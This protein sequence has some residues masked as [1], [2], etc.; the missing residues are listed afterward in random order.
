MDEENLHKIAQKGEDSGT[1]F[2]LD[3][4]SPDAMA[5]EIVSFLNANG[6]TIYLGVS[7][8]GDIVGL[9]SESVRR[10]NQMI[11]NVATQHIR[12][13]VALFTENILLS[14]SKVVIAIKI[15]EGREKPYFDRNGIAWIKE[16]A[17]KRKIV[18]REEIRR[19]FESSG[20]LHA[21]EQWTKAGLDRLDKAAFKDF[22]R[23]TYNFQ[24]PTKVSEMSRIVRN[25]NLATDDGHLNLAGLLLFGNHPEFLFPQFCVKAVRLKGN[26]LATESFDD[27][28]DYVGTLPAIYAGVTFFV[29]RNLHKRQSAAGIN[30]PGQSEIHPAVVEEVLVNALLHRDYYVNAP[31]RVLIFDD[32][33]EVL[34]PGSLPNHLTVE[35]ILAGNTNIRNPILASFVAKGILPYH[36]LGSGIMRA[37]SLCPDI[38]FVDDKSGV[39][40][41]VV[42]PR[43]QV[44]VT[45]IGR[46]EM[47]FEALRENPT[48]P[49]RSLAKKMN[50]SL[51]TIQEYVGALKAE[52]RLLREGGTRGKWLVASC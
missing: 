44:A 50:V 6:G 18:S 9:D 49:L 52:G 8:S 34:S 23:K 51:S 46:K 20:Q 43:G 21:D 27:S 33:M 16:G 7:D 15:E 12:N 14:N 3:V 28:E 22:F 30:A 41:K 11:S 38:Q 25:M 2:K 40:F 19:F 5:A 39:L 24:L 4:T 36:G 10:L 48:L 42:I 13:P 1:Q 45:M 29:N 47:V 26:T 17:D 32:R 37:K 31:I 35:K